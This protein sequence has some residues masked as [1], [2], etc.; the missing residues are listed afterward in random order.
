MIQEMQ[1]EAVSKG[2]GHFAKDKRPNRSIHKIILVSDV[3]MLILR[4]PLFNTNPVLRVSLKIE[5]I[6][7][8][9]I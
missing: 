7:S 5:N 2:E 3:E 1:K 8:Q 4:L 6:Y 9:R